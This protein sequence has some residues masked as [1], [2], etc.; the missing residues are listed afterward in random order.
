MTFSSSPLLLVAQ[1]FKVFS[2]V[3]VFAFFMYVRSFRI[4]SKLNVFEFIRIWSVVFHESWII[5]FLFACPLKNEFKQTSILFVIYY[6][7][8]LFVSSHAYKFTT[9]RAIRNSVVIDIPQTNS[10]HSYS[11]V[12]VIKNKTTGTQNN[13]FR[14]NDAL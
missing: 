1:L 11:E 14:P 6:E 12:F 3:I 2:Q 13:F 10:I 4:Y 5:L 9:I 7:L 8:S